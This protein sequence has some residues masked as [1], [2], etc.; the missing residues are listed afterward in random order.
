ML[1]FLVKQAIPVARRCPIF[2]DNWLLLA[3]SPGSSEPSYLGTKFIFTGLQW[4]WYSGTVCS[5]EAKPVRDAN[6]SGEGPDWRS[7]VL[8]PVAL[9]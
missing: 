3:P 1:N 9:H 2:I 7:S 8:K 5:R 4:K 6:E